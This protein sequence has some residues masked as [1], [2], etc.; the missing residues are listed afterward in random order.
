M[1]YLRNLLKGDQGDP[2]DPGPKGDQGDPGPKGDQGD[3][4]TAGA[5]GTSVTIIG[6]L[7]STDDLPGS[8]SAGQAYTIGGDLYVWATGSS[9]WVNVG[10]IRGPK[11]DPGDP[12]ADGADGTNGTNGTNGSNGTNGTSAT[13]AIGTVT[14]GAAGSSAT[15]ANVGT[16]SAAVLNIS[17]PKGDTGAKGDKGDKGDPGTPGTGGGG[18]SGIVD[19]QSLGAVGNGTHDDTAAILAARDSGAAVVWFG[20]GTYLTDDIVWDKEVQ[21]WGPGS[22]FVTIKP[23][24]SGFGFILR[25]PTNAAR[26]QIK[27]ITLDGSLNTQ[28]STKCGLLLQRSALG[29]D[30]VVKNFNGDGARY[31]PYDASTTD[32][33]GGSIGNAAFFSLWTHCKFTDNGG[34]GFDVRFGANCN[35]FINCQFIRNKGDGWHHRT[36][37]QPTYGNWRLG[38]QSSYNSGHGDNIESG[39]DI[40]TMALYTEY[41]HTPTNQNTDGYTG[42]DVDIFVGDDV[43]RSKI[44]VGVLLNGLSSHV[45]APAVGLNTSCGVFAGPDRLFTSAA[46]VTTKYHT[47]HQIP[48]PANCTATD[49]AGI[50]AF[51]NTNLIGK[52]KTAGERS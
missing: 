16:S 10:P 1:S 36:D 42:S 35:G 4:G 14:T 2:G 8:G 7:A 33:S 45:R 32:G 3:P 17:I 26:M 9:T 48:A 15:V 49:I 47:P 41:N 22:R 50:V 21:I 20:P 37:G 12:G 43:S 27:G 38:G 19:V 25:P 18:L 31:A 13:V 46:G 44:E 51:I 28:A 5:D 24:G 30:V 11:G 29:E 34:D 39:T 23:T 52:S 40:T 6:E